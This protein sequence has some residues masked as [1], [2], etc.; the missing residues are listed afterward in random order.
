[1]AYGRSRFLA[2]GTADV[3][4]PNDVVIEREAVGWH[5]IALHIAYAHC[6][7]GNLVIWLASL[8]LAGN[9]CMPHTLTM[10]RTAPGPNF[11]P[12]VV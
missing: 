1:M 6:S 9:M 12:I 7:V 3:V 10:V 11:A 5:C 8:K 4:L 2:N